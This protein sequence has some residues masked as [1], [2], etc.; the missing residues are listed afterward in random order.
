MDLGRITWQN[1]KW[2]RAKNTVTKLQRKI[3]Q[4]ALE[5]TK[6]KPHIYQK[7]LLESD[8]AKLLAV[9]KVTQDNRGKKTPGIDGIKFLNPEERLK[10]AKEIRIDGKTSPIRRVYIPKPGTDEKRPPGIPTIRD[11]AKQALVKMTLEPEWETKFE[12]NSYGFRPGRRAHDAFEAIHH[13]LRA[14]GKFVLDADISKCF[15]KINHDQL[16]N[17]LDTL[18]EMSNQIKVWLKAGV[19]DKGAY[20]PTS[21]G[22]PQGGVISPLLSNI[23]LHGME[24]HLKNWITTRSL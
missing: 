8:S 7:R 17:K 9:R 4:A 5:N 18:P 19:S 20:L 15:D 10:L 21:T 23:A 1:V 11:R 13:T 12:P 3:F 6:E 16:L 14:T 22:T 24:T 2:R